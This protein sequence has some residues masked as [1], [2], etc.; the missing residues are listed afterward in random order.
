MKTN[1]C[2]I[3]CRIDTGEYYCGSSSYRY[4]FQDR[5]EKDIDKAK[6]Y[7]R[8]CDCSNAVTTMREQFKEAKK[9][10]FMIRVYELVY[11]CAIYLK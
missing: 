10:S 8:K 11:Y 3:L 7:K 5:W 1:L 9:I 4:L 6:K 2:Y